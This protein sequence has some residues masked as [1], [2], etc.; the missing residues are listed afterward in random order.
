M[1]RISNLTHSYHG[2]LTDVRGVS[3]NGEDAK[4]AATAE[5][6]TITSDAT[7]GAIGNFEIV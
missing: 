5:W 4:D 7:E 6:D 3:E 1:I 2:V